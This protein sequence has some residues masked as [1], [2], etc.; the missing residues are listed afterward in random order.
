MSPWNLVPG[1]PHKTTVADLLK[2][3]AGLAPHVLVYLQDPDDLRPE[4]T[5]VLLDGGEHDE[6]LPRNERGEPVKPHYAYPDLLNVNQIKDVV[7]WA[8]VEASGMPDLDVPAFMLASLAH[9]VDTGLFLAVEDFLTEPVEE[10]P[11]DLERFAY[12]WNGEQPGWVVLRVPGISRLLY[13][14]PTQALFSDPSET[15]HHRYEALIDAA[16]ANGVSE[17]WAT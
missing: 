14:R 6:Y 7:A 11:V 1:K 12:L 3:A 2:D 5:T 4:A 16:I 17:E 9:Y 8:T 13:H 10:E 15:R